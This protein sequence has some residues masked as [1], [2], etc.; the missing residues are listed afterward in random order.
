MTKRPISV[1]V[2]N[3]KTTSDKIRALLRE[4]YLRTEIAQFLD[5]RY[6]HVRKVAVDA[7]IEDGVH[8]GIAVVSKAKSIS[9]VREDVAI[10]V[11]VDAGFEKVGTWVGDGVGGIALDTGAPRDAGV[12]AF[13][14]QGLIKYVGVSR[15][16]IRTRMA[17]YRVGQ[18]GQRTSARVNQIINEHVA[19]GTVVEV[20][21]ATPPA[22][23]WN[24]LPVVTA[25]GLEA[26]LIKMIQ[27]PWNKAGM[28]IR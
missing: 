17:N 9:K 2:E 19:A 7:G 13:V 3:L 8:R 18:K 4:G 6:Q 15:A 14:V 27:P 22:L 21:V 5:I 16:G 12:Y 26:G 25:A 28:R 1:V 23:Q 20:Y 24:G 10:E 11:L